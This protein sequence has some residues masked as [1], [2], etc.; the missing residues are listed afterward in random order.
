MKP[1]VLS[2]FAGI[3]LFTQSALA[4]PTD[5]RIGSFAANW[6]GFPST[7][8]LSTKE[9]GR[10]IFSGEI[11]IRRTGQVDRIKVEQHSDNSLTMWRY[12]SGRD[13]GKVQTSR[14]HVPQRAFMGGRRYVLFQ[15]LKNYGPGCQDTT[16]WLRMPE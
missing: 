5:L 12:L 14:M 13:N 3:I 7:I 11:L 10:W 6:C 2:V 4:G 15:S 9:P 1:V 16:S 8:T